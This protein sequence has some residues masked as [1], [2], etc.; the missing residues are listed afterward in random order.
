MRVDPSVISFS[1]DDNYC[2]KNCELLLVLRL[3]YF[4]ETYRYAYEKG[5]LISLST[6]GSRLN[7]KEV[8]NLLAEMPPYTLLKLNCNIKLK[9]FENYR[10]VK[11]S[12][13]NRSDEYVEKSKGLLSQIL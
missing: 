10:S 6:N 7:K 9:L 1:Q 11:F 5:F 12:V 8:G 13:L 2:V 4:I 3:L